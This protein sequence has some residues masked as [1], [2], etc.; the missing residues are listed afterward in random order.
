[1]KKKDFISYARS[2]GMTNYKELLIAM[3]YNERY[4]DRR[5]P[6]DDLNSKFIETFNSFIS[7]KENNQ[8]VDYDMD[9]ETETEVDIEEAPQQKTQSKT[10]GLDIS[11]E[12]Y[13]SSQKLGSSKIKLL[14]ENA[15][16][17]KA[18]YIT[19]EMTSK[20]TDALIIGSLVHTLVSEPHKLNEEYLILDMPKIPIKAD[21]V[22]AINTLG[23]SV[24]MKRN[25]DGDEIVANTVSE[26]KEHYSG[27]VSG[28]NKTIVT[29]T[30]YEIAKEVSQKALNSIFVIEKNNR[31][32]LRAKLK[33]VIAL[34]SCYVEKTFYGVIDGVEVQVRPDILVN[35]SASGQ[36]WYVI[37]LKTAEDSTAS[38]FTKQSAN[39][40]YDIQNWLYVE[41]L[42]QNGIRVQEFIFNVS[43]KKKFSGSAYYK[44][45]PDD[46]ENAG[47]LTRS[48]IGKYKYCLRE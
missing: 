38:L 19:K 21:L 7:S 47:K 23:G 36:L 12:E 2:I 16:E 32:I 40:Y 1:M 14:L 15:M 42:R 5:K 8:N 17:F 26:L 44:L 28:S 35:L 22:S 31:E 39:F 20:K 34:D 45:N 18:R 11:N 29:A 48:I 9:I 30:Q 33:D 43:G 13:H 46:V 37:D 24:E 25:S 41:V 27:L 3:G 10:I 6:N 4:M